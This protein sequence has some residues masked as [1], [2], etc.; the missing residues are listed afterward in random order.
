M[1][2]QAAAAVKEEP[3]GT[4][5][6]LSLFGNE[7]SDALAG[8]F[9]GDFDFDG[10]G[11]LEDGDIKLR[12]LLFNLKGKTKGGDRLQQDRFVDSITEQQQGEIECVWLVRE[13]SNTYARYNEKEEKNDIICSSDFDRHKG[14][15]HDGT[16]RPCK[17]CPDAKWHT[18]D[19]GKRGRNC[20][21][22]HWMVGVELTTGMPFVVKFKR[23][24]EAA[25]KQYLQR[26]H[27]GRRRMKSGQITN[28][29][30]FAFRSKVTLEMHDSGNYALPVIDKGE[31]VLDRAQ[32]LELVEQAK[33][34]REWLVANRRK[35]EEAD[36]SSDPDTPDT[37]FNTDDFGGQ[38]GQDIV[39]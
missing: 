1:G 34:A 20:S 38:Q 31:P 11:P 25:L 26:H 37:S 24:S 5:T 19:K 7:G 21:T 3:K 2:K 39:T 36:A 4:G 33:T 6:A 8:V 28:Y 30:L 9:D 23:T 14:E 29:P 32:L 15:M 10:L 27:L 35:F 17:D 18:D 13:R 16:I 12:L 22:V